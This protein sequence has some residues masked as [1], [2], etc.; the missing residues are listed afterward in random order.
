MIY[1]VTT[2]KN[3][4]DALEH[5]AYAAPSLQLEGFIHMSMK[6]QVQGVLERYYQGMNNLVLLHID[7]SKLKAELKYELSPSVNQEFPHLFGTL[8]VDAVV[9]VE[10]VKG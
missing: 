9:E 6:H 4:E 2:Q 5:G 7:E 1:H 3:W 8:N 10:P